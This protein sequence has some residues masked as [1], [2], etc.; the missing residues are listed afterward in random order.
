[1]HNNYDGVRTRLVMGTRDFIRFYHARMNAL[2]KY[3]R[4]FHET[5]EFD[6]DHGTPHMGETLAF[7]MQ[8]FANSLPRPDVWSHI[9]V[10]PSFQSG[11]GVLPIARNLIDG[12]RNV[13][14]RGFRS[15]VREWLP[16][17]R[18]LQGVKLRITETGSIAQRGAGCHHHSHTRRRRAPRDRAGGC[19]R[20][21]ALRLTVMR[22]KSE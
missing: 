16:A 5:A 9:D 7:H 12:A 14:R 3:T 8:A 10:Y 18:L 22:I 2:W 21:P 11:M 6:A 20:P 1:M 19:G 15:S 13:S 17:G 4:P